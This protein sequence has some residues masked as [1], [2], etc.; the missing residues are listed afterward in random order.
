MQFLILGMVVLVVWLLLAQWLRGQTMSTWTRPLI[1][2]LGGALIVLSILLAMRGL[3]AVAAPLAML[4]LWLM[5]AQG[6]GWSGLPGSGTKTS[7]QTSHVRTDYLDVSLDHDSGELRGEVIKGRYQGEALEAMSLEQLVDMLATC[8]VDDPPSAQIIE[9]V[10]DRADPDW[11]HKFGFAGGSDGGGDDSRVYD[12][13][14][15]SQMSR[16]YAYQVLGLEPGASEAEIRTAHRELM[17]KMHPDR[18]GSTVLAAQ[19]NEAKQVL[20]G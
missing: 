17:Q 4:G 9:T 11:R 18:G 13:D 16:A 5:S 15:T 12:S 6:G 7:G 8:A 10:L 3:G 19:I 1:M 20:L 2:A 14:G